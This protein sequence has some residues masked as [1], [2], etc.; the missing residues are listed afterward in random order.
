MSSHWIMDRLNERIWIEG[1]TL[2]HFV[3]TSFAAGLN[4]RNAD[5]R[6]YLFTMDISPVTEASVD[7]KS[8]RIE[9][10]AWGTGYHFSDVRKESID[11][12]WPLKGFSAVFYYYT[13]PGLQEE[14]ERRGVSFREESLNF[15]IRD[16]QL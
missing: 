13:E 15:K 16:F 3:Q 7:P 11:K 10:K 6:G 12:Q 2:Y 4:S 8:K 9:F 5:E 1:N 14:L